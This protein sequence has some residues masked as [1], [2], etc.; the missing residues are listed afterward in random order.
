MLQTWREVGWKAGEHSVHIDTAFTLTRF[1]SVISSKT[2]TK[3]SV[4]EAESCR[5]DP[6]WDLLTEPGQHGSVRLFGDKYCKHLYYRANCFQSDERAPSGRAQFAIVSGKVLRVAYERFLLQRYDR[7]R[8]DR[9][10]SALPHWHLAVQEIQ[11]LLESAKW[12]NLFSKDY[13]WRNEQG[14][15]QQDRGAVQVEDK[16]AEAEIQED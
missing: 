14:R 8:V 10:R 12:D 3:R 4:N 13:R 9:Q 7:Q 15:L 2:V 5:T 16:K 1:G 11:T 6:R